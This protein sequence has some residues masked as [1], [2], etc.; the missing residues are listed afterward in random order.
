MSAHSL[1]NVFSLGFRHSLLSLPIFACVRFHFLCILFAVV[2]IRFELVRSLSRRLGLTA[3]T[4]ACFHFPLGSSVCFILN[5]TYSNLSEFCLYRSIVALR[6]N[7]SILLCLVRKY[8]RLF[9]SFF[10]LINMILYLLLNRVLFFVMNSHQLLF[11]FLFLDR[12][13]IFA[14]CYSRDSAQ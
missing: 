5:C 4:H 1:F 7:I 9:S 6:F 13:P 12:V 2:M 8:I 14:G 11:A 10:L 3:V